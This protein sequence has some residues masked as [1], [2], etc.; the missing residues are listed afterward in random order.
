M[1]AKTRKEHKL[2]DSAP[3]KGALKRLSFEIRDYRTR[4][5]I[6]MQAL[7][8][9]IGCTHYVI[10]HIEQGQNAPSF[11]V[12][13]SMNARIPGLVHKIFT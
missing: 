12:L 11:A 6:S 10:A 7:A 4:N 13:A 8:R 9:D 1:P 5:G 2:S 3:A